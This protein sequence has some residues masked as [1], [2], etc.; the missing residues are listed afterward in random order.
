M[1]MG[2]EK[3]ETVVAMQTQLLIDS[4]VLTWLCVSFFRDSV[5]A[6]SKEKLA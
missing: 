5:L 3:S 2:G 4:V 1:M 6:S